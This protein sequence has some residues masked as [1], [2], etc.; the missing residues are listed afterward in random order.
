MADTSLSERVRSFVCD[1][2]HTIEQLETI[3]LMHDDPVAT[4][5]AAAVASR[6]R[7]DAQLAESA[8]ER[9]VKSE[10]CTEKSGSQ[11]TFAYA[12]DVAS[13]HAIGELVAVYAHAR[14]EVLML[15]STCAM[16]RI[17]TAQLHTFAQAFFMRKPS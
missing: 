5:T 10:L 13:A 14:V 11:R 15:I 4:W 3:L 12:P 16:E 6:L 8:L 9:C 17:R 1:R 7:I 2:I